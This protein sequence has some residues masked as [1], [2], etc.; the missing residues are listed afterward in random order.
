MPKYHFSGRFQKGS[1]INVLE[2]IKQAERGAF[3]REGEPWTHEDVDLLLEG[4]LVREWCDTS[5]DPERTTFQTE[6]GRSWHS[7]QTKLRKVAANYF[8]SATARI[9]DG[10]IYLPVSRT[11]RTTLPFLERDLA[12]IEKAAGDEGRKSGACE[13]ERLGKI[14][15]RKP[16]QLWKQ[17]LRLALSYQPERPGGLFRSLLKVKPSLP[18]CTTP[19]QLAESLAAALKGRWDTTLLKI[20]G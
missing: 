13:P 12:L 7:W 9:R 11:D 17:L 8:G 16:E 18:E 3:F 5:P 19:V 4:F 14:L 20:N 10:D 1:V 6:L 15:G 2:G